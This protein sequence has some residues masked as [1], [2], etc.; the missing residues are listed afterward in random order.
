MQLVLAT[1]LVHITHFI[2][3]IIAI[4]NV[5]K[6]N[7]ILDTEKSYH[8]W[9]YI[10]NVQCKSERDRFVDYATEHPLEQRGPWTYSMSD[11]YHVFFVQNEHVWQYCCEF[12][13]YQRCA[14]NHMAVY[15]ARSRK[16]IKENVHNDVTWQCYPYDYKRDCIATG[17]WTSYII[18]FLNLNTQLVMKLL[19]VM[20]IVIW[21]CCF[22]A[23]C[24]R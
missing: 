23:M 16:Y 5:V 13:L 10:I 12:L 22:V 15:C 20:A 3:S 19:L 14:L 8:C 7:V 1:F 6:E 9:H 4:E 24:T 17:S 18:R 21:L 2:T 11:E